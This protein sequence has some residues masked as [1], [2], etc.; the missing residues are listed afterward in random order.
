MAATLSGSTAIPFLE[1][2]WPKSQPHGTKN[3][4]LAALMEIPYSLHCLKH[5]F[6]HSAWC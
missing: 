6:K 1:T 4:D 5:C 2:M 3:L